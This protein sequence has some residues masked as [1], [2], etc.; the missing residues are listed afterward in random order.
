MDET[1]L[2]L[3]NRPPAER[4]NAVF[5]A[6]ESLGPCGT[7]TVIN[8][9]DPSPLLQQMTAE[10]ASFDADASSVER[11]APDRFEA[12]LEKRTDGSTNVGEDRLED[13]VLDAIRTVR[14]PELGLDVVEAGMVASIEHGSQSASGSPGVAVVIDA[15]GVDQSLIEDFEAEIEAAIRRKTPYEEVEVRRR[16][17]RGARTVSSDEVWDRLADVTHPDLDGDVVETGVVTDVGVSDRTVSVR[18]EEPDLS[19]DLDEYRGE[20]LELLGHAAF[21]AHGVAEV[22]VDT[23]DVVVP[24]DPPRGEDPPLADAPGASGPPGAQGPSP[25]EHGANQES[26]APP[27]LHLSGID[28]V[29]LVASAKGGVGKTTV[30]TQL[31]RSLAE[32]GQDVGLLDSDFT[33][34]DVPQLLDLEPRF[35]D[36]TVI[37]PVDRAGIEVMSVGLMENRPTAWN[38][39]MIHNALFNLLEDVEW[40]VETLVVDLPPGASDT[41]MTFLQFVPIDGVVLVT[42]PHPT[43]IA[44]TNVGATLFKEGD[45]PVLGVIVNMVRAACPNCGD[46]HDLFPG[47]DLE[48]ALEHPILA[49]LPFSPEL[50]SFSGEPPARFARMAETIAE[51]IPS[52]E[53]RSVPNDAIDVRGLPDHGRFEMVEDA[54]VARGPDETLTIVSDRHPAGLAVALV[55]VLDVD[56]SPS[57]VF[58]EYDVTAN[59]ADEWVLRVRK[60]TEPD[61]TPA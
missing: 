2:D 28:D 17:G 16:S 37:E 4:H 8:D 49:E 47:T 30:A 39:E 44:D 35:S 36:G 18:I 6:F 41:L 59:A 43:S 25:L 34:P 14:D 27:T 33:G 21:N 45:V 31:A 1:T 19:G 54:F 52:N 32:L 10:V 50:R 55:D 5:E 26:S 51:S 53:A 56:G 58:E 20:F 60:P 29:V 12:K 57:E 11:L 15:M 40:S 9:H 22:R 38:G 7:L 46:E 42:T 23:G 13:A 61:V 3:R 24:I 48:E